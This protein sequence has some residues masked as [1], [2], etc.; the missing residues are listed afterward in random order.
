MQNLKDKLSNQQLEELH[1]FGHPNSYEMM[2]ENIKPS[3]GVVF[4]GSKGEI[5]AG[6]GFPATSG[7]TSSNSD[8]KRMTK[9]EYDQYI[10]ME[11]NYSRTESFK[12]K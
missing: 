9:K 7:Q 2:I 3:Q 12:P 8:V 11:G 1:V 6:E 10:K 5:K 4:K